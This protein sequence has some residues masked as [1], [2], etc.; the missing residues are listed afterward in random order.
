MSAEQVFAAADE[1]A[2]KAQHA[3]DELN[4][5]RLV[6]MENVKV[7]CAHVHRR[8]LCCFTRVV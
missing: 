4:E 5:N 8:P 6:T 7:S 3:V 1:W 2:A